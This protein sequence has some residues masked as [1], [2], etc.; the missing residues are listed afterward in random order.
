MALFWLSSGSHLDIS[1]PP[2]VFEAKEWDLEAIPVADDFSGNPDDVPRKMIL[3]LFLLENFRKWL[4]V[5]P[6]IVCVLCECL[7][8]TEF[9]I[10][11]LVR[12]IQEPT[13]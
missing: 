13:C 6:M 9:R 5:L 1:E 10:R 8:K 11:K 12:Y 7:D 4:L 3:K 2:V